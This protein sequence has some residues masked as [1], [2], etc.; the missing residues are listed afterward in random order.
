MT[1]ELTPEK[2]GRRNY[3]LSKATC[4]AFSSERA[5]QRKL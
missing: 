4:L 3:C 5:D 1:Y 2:A